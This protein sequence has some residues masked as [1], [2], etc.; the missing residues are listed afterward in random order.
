MDLAIRQ[1]LR[2]TCRY[3]VGAVL[4]VG[5]RVL[6]AGPNLRRNNPRIDLRHATF[7]AE[8]VVLRKVRTMTPGA[9]IF[10]ARVNREGFPLMAQPCPRC[11][12]ALARAGIRRAHYTVAHRT[13]DDMDIPALPH[14]RTVYSF[15]HAIGIKR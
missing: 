13:V 7:H 1:A 3:R 15:R 11:Q 5:N 2:S 10:V 6:A 9:E 12:E 14:G 8:E 4:A